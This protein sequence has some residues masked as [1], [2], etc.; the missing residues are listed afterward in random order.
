MSCFDLFIA[1][2]DVPEEL[3]VRP[4]PEEPKE[5]LIQ[6]T[7]LRQCQEPSEKEVDVAVEPDQEQI[8][9]PLCPLMKPVQPTE[10]KVASVPPVP[11]VERDIVESDWERMQLDTHE[12][13]SNVEEPAHINVERS[14]EMEET[15]KAMEAPYPIKGGNSSAN[16]EGMSMQQVKYL[17]ILKTLSFLY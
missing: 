10:Q 13:D 14:E 1:V 15:H 12:P 9:A 16:Q 7:K 6:S 5:F 17:Y 4:E 2:E 3:E 11:P 8:S